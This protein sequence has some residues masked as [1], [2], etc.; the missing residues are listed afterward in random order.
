MPVLQLA[1]VLDPTMRAMCAKPYEGHPRGCPNFQKKAGCPGTHPGAAPLCAEFFDLSRPTYFIYSKFDL[2][3]HVAK[4]K[5]AHPDW[6]QRQLV[7]CLYWQGT[8]R[9]A[10]TAEVA[11][12]YQRM[13]PYLLGNAR[14]IT[15]CPEALGV[16]VT[17]T[18]KQGGVILQWPPTTETTHVAM[19]GWPKVP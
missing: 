14:Q 2:G 7:C 8:A 5:A 11:A 16:N 10:L 19:A 1:P 4:M 15:T 18:M 12:F 6:S 3:A 9:K 13:D 17:E